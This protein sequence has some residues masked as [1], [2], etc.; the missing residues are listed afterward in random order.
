MHEIVMSPEV[1][2]ETYKKVGHEINESLKNEDKRP[3]LVCVMKGAMTFLI[4]MMKYI[5]I[6]VLVDYIHISS[7]D[8]TNSSGK[9]NL[10]KD[11]TFNPEGRTVVIVEDVCDTGL[12]LSYLKDYIKE[13]Y[14][15]KDVKIAVFV[16]KTARRKTHVDLDYV[17]YTMNVD[18]YIVGNGFDYYDMWRNVPYVFTPSKEDFEAWDK[19]VANDPIKKN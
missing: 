7:Y 6:P 3:L 14:H 13:K 11:L 4:G 2:E 12:S 10:L 17:G 1:I 9:V 16:D 15:P 18:K 8:G 19:I 5:E